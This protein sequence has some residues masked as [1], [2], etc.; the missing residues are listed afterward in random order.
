MAKCFSKLRTQSV[1]HVDFEKRISLIKLLIRRSVHKK[2]TRLNA[3]SIENIECRRHSMLE[4]RHCVFFPGEKRNHISIEQR[5]RQIMEGSEHLKTMISQG[6]LSSEQ[7]K[8]LAEATRPRRCSFSSLEP[9]SHSTPPLL[10]KKPLKVP[11]PHLPRPA[12][13]SLQSRRPETSRPMAIQITPI[14]R[15]LSSVSA[16]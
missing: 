15:R 5:H 8:S 13:S 3:P 9:T 10:I 16:W 2:L 6:I 1:R 7:I 14:K 11:R 4:G 12:L